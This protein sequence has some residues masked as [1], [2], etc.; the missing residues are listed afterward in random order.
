MKCACGCGR[1]TPIS[2]TT[3]KPVKFAK[4]NHWRNVPGYTAVAPDPVLLQVREQTGLDGD[5]LYEVRIL[6]YSRGD[7]DRLAVMMGAE[8]TFVVEDQVR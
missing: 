7:L 4:K 2:K 8:L 3:G 5:L 1:D 6:T